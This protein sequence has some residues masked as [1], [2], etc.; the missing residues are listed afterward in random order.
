MSD[1]NETPV[2]KPTSRVVYIHDNQGRLPELNTPVPV[3]MRRRVGNRVAG[4][5]AIC[6]LIEDVF[7]PG[8]KEWVRLDS[9]NDKAPQ[10]FAWI[11]LQPAVDSWNEQFLQ[12]LTK[13]GELPL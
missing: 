12:N 11:D 7:N 10:P 8:V 13:L 1:I 3:I 5:I 6:C 2:Q 4:V 9:D